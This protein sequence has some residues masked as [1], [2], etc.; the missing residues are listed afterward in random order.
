MNNMP[1]RKVNRDPNR[2]YVFDTTLRDG[3]Q[4]P[5]KRDGVFTPEEKEEI[6]R[7]LAKAGADIIEAGFTVS[8]PGD[9]EAISRI[10]KKVQGPVI[11]SLARTVPEDID[12]AWE[13]VE[14]AKYNGGARIHVFVPSSPIL[15]EHSI[16]KTSEEV[17][18]ATR[19]AVKRAK[20]YTDDV[21]FSP[22]DA[23]RSSF[24][25]MMRVIFE[26]I[27]QGATT[28]NIP[29]T[30]GIAQPPEYAKRIGAAK[31]MIDQHIG[32]NRIIVSAHCHNDLGLA[33]ANTLAALRAGA[34][35]VEVAINGIGE[36][37]GNTA[38]E[39]V[40]ENI[41]NRPDFFGYRGRPLYTVMDPKCLPDLSRLVAEKS[42]MLV[43]PNKAIVGEHA[44]RDGS[45]IHQNAVIENEKS[46]HWMPAE[47]IGK[48]I[49]IV[50]TNQSG[51]KA[52]A[53][54]AKETGITMPKKESK[55]LSPIVKDFMTKRRR[56]ITHTELEKLI[57]EYRNEVLND[58]FVL[59]SI[60]MHSVNSHSSSKVTIFIDGK[61]HQVE[62]TGKGPIDAAV[63]AIKEATGLDIEIESLEEASLGSGSD[64]KAGCVLTVKNSIQITSYAE[65]ESVPMAAV[66]AYVA[67]LN[68]IYRSE[69]R[70][71]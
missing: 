66:K 55:N 45:G 20:G 31:R 7:K 28:I 36:R 53:K 54:K 51:A 27:D 14:P 47:E 70:K 26:A 6:A 8:Y 69:Q 62:G 16:K 42:K 37:A 56:T 4:S 12:R 21:E 32:R 71:K 17:I 58:R 67:A 64:A 1:E 10:A 29:D 3:N 35:Q 2:V 11:C 52:V 41:R 9:F 40:T 23:S 50:L 46:Y 39:E 24:D 48:S 60:E 13:A 15:M 18:A 33:T 68:T 19:E 38:L 65:D 34:R 61:Q 63:C 25:F 5:V 59:G 44:H 43:P 22:E 57:A 30:V 49:E